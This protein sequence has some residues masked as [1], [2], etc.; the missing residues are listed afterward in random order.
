MLT[1]RLF[2]T[3]ALQLEEQSLAQLVTGRTAALLTY[4]AVT[5][6]P[7]PRSHLADIFWDNVAEQKARSNLRYTLRNL[8]K[9][10]GDY[11]VVNGETVAFNHDL[12]HW[13]DVTVFADVMATS[14]T[15]AARVL[16][17][18]ILQESL[19]LYA[20]EFLAGFQIDNAPAFER[21]QLAQRR[22]LHDLFIQGLQLRTQQHLAEG[23][24]EEG[25]A[26]NE[27]LLTLE[28]WREEIHRQ[29]MLLLAHNGQRSARTQTIHALL[30]DIGRRIGCT[31]Y[32]KDHCTLR[33]DQVRRLVGRPTSRQAST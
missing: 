26:V 18:S 7:Q 3:L 30:P 29:R 33:T 21:W 4:L 22:H 32:G 24:Y 19:N 16:E 20:G 8:R 28:P 5:R 2:G 10:V 13:I 9:I 27:H 1:A 31:A 23:A 14:P 25:L 6:Q 15:L 12:P 11:V 17:P